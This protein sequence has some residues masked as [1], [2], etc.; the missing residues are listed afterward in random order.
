MRLARSS[1][2]RS[3]R[4]LALISAIIAVVVAAGLAASLMTLAAATN[5]EAEGR[6]HAMGADYLAQG[7]VEV[8]RNVLRTSIARGAPPPPSG[9][10]WIEGHPVGFDIETVGPTTVSMDDSGLQTFVTSFQIKGTAETSG[11]STQANRIVNVE[12]TPIFQF[13]LFYE[14][15]LELWPGPPM[16]LSGRVHSN[17][18]IYF[19]A[20][21]SLTLDTNYVRCVGNLYGHRKHSS[22]VNDHVV[23]FRRWVADPFDA[24]EPV[25][26]VDM[27]NES[28]MSAVG[29][30]TA[31]GFDS[32]F[33]GY[34]SDGDGDFDDPGD[35]KPWGPGAL[36]FW[37]E[38]DFYYSGTGNT[39]STGVHGVPEARVPEVDTLGM[40]VPA[41]S[42]AG[43]DYEWHAASRRY[44]PVPTGTGSHSKGPFH[45]DATFTLIT[46]DDGTWQAYDK[47]GDEIIAALPGVVSMTETYDARQAEGSGEKIDVTV[48]DL[49]ALELSGYFPDNGLL[50]AATYGTGTGLDVKGIQLTNGAELAGPLSVVSENS[51]YVQGD[52]N[53]VDKKPAAV[54]ADAVNLLSNAWDNS[55]VPGSIPIADETAYNFGMVTGNTESQWGIYNGGV[56]NLPRF[57]ENWAGKDCRLNGSITCLWNSKYANAE[58]SGVPDL[59]IPPQRVWS[60]DADFNDPANLPP[61]TPMSVT[62]RNVVSW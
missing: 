30:P 59:R 31:S 46:F 2:R 16:T 57:H 40:F 7:A 37:S 9:D 22:A 8:A 54:I 45:A 36:D 12:A 35:W 44:V 48:I 33:A 17:A 47:F 43:G 23:R 18:N 38:P 41:T 27:Y 26:F 49:D 55:K 53:V 6:R 28:Q 61:F 1:R 51:I 42:A 50:Y 58:H 29:V 60:Y 4:G 25:E 34:D 10:S 62:V 39:V 13:A 32:D 20:G 52:Y 24:S 19:G 21:N 14:N 56:E 15:D 11:F 3:S 5:R